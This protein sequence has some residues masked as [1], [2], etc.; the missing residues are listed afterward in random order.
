MYLVDTN[1]WLERLL[2]QEKADDVRRFLEHTSPRNLYITDFT[3]HSIGVILA[4]LARLEA[5]IDFA[6]DLFVEGGVNLI[7]IKPE[8]TPDLVTV[9]NEY[10]L[11][12]D[13]AYQYLAAQYEGLTL[14]SFDSDFERTDGGKKT[15]S[16]ILRD[17]DH[18]FPNN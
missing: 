10:K 11:D 1:V 13:D 16:E 18:Q 8:N 2:N 7:A 4:R 3:F 14:V 15:P 6:Q 17:A 5:L 12:F 9:M